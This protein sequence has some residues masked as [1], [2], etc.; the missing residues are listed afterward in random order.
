M[1]MPAASDLMLMPSYGQT[2]EHVMFFGF[3]LI[4]F[5]DKCTPFVS[6]T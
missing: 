3:K 6:N 2:Q 5:R 1:V 4:D